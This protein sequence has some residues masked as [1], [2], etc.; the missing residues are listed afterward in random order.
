MGTD[1]LIR[2]MRSIDMKACI[3]FWV[4]IRSRVRWE[5]LV[6]TFD[7]MVIFD[8]CTALKTRIKPA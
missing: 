5:E 7:W 1:V 4:P 6:R 8:L 2:Q 3:I